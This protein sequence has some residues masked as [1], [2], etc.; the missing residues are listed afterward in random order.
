MLAYI[1]VVTFIFIA[2]TYVFTFFY[3]RHESPFRLHH[4]RAPCDVYVRPLHLF[5]LRVA[6]K[7]PREPASIQSFVRN[8]MLPRF[9]LSTAA[10]PF[11][12][13]LADDAKADLWSTGAVLYELVTAKHPFGGANQVRA[14][15]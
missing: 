6:D 10:P 13:L 5:R 14:P 2:L 8:L 1:L 11:S 12:S 7:Q 15:F 4:A 3:V 9:L